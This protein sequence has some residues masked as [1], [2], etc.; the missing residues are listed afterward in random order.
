MW[1]TKETIT[2]LTSRSS[3][4]IS[5]VLLK[6]HYKSYEYQYLAMTG[7]MCGRFMRLI[8]FFFESIGSTFFL[9]KTLLRMTFCWLKQLFI[10]THKLVA[11]ILITRLLLFI[12]LTILSQSQHKMFFTLFQTITDKKFSVTKLEVTIWHFCVS[13]YSIIWIDLYFSYSKKPSI[14]S[15]WIWDFSSPEIKWFILKT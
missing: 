7:I 15:F 1:S 12:T 11:K 3:V 14:N 8:L 6:Y 5:F 9:K 4:L 2:W 13:N 10:Q